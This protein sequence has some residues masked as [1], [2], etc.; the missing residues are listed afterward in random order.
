[1]CHS[2]CARVCVCVHTWC[3]KQKNKNEAAAFLSSYK[4]QIQFYSFLS[5]TGIPIHTLVFLTMVSRLS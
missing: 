5:S 3:T 1:M 2:V 4:L